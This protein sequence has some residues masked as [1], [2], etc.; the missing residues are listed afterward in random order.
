[1]AP[2]VQ[3]SLSVL[4]HTN[5]RGLKKPLH[6]SIFMFILLHVT[7]SNL[8]IQKLSYQLPQGVIVEDPLGF[9]GG[10]AYTVFK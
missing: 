2:P 7:F 5:T 9:N 1:M 4:Y 10:T 6:T 3:L 8:I